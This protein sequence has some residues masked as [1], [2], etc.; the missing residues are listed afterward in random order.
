MVFKNYSFGYLPAIRSHL[1]EWIMRF[2]I[3]I[4]FLTGFGLIGKEVP[5]EKATFAGGCFWCMQ[6]PYDKMAGVKKVTVG[7]TGGEKPN[8][9][10]EEVCSGKTGHTE[11]VEIEFNPEE[12]SF[13]ELLQVFWTNIDPTQ[14]NGQFYDKGSQY[15][16][17]IFYHSDKQKELAEKSKKE[18]ESS[19]KFQESI[20][21][22]ITKAGIFYPAEEYHQGY[23]KKNP[24]HYQRYSIG[25][26]R[27]EY[28]RKT[29][30]KEPK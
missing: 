27:V 9:T 18:L 13:E 26:G 4:F 24:G 19:G 21:T 30:G 6:P 3:L 1:W 11:A 25:S 16:T 7:Y 8:P 28:L 22:E 14:V 12:V 2:S 10:Y 20:A 5:L 23:Y 17:G 29:W 15:R